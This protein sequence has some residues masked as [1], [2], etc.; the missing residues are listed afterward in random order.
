MNLRTIFLASLIATAPAYAQ[1]ASDGTGETAGE[2]RP[3]AA[4]NQQADESERAEESGE[5]QICRR[6]AQESAR[7]ISTTRR[8]CMTAREWREYNRRNN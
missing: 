4:A 5:R 7:H 6:A 8:I 1:A 2:S 3:T